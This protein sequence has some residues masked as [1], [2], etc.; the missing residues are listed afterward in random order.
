MDGMGESRA[1]STAKDTEPYEY[2]CLRPIE[3]FPAEVGGRQVVCLRDP[4]QYS[5]AVIYVP[6]E[7]A[8]IL[9][10][11]DGGHSLLDIQAAFARRFGSLLFREQLLEVIRSLDESLL[12]DSP[13]FAEHR[14]QVEA[15]FQAAATRPAALAGK[16]Y[17]TESV[18]L[19][20]TLDRFFQHTDGPGDCPPRAEAARLGA[21]V[22]P[23]IDYGRGGPCYAWGYREAAGLPE[24]DR[25]LILGTVH[26][27]IRRPFALSRK[28]FET[29]LGTVAI[30][31]EFLDRLVAGGA[32]VYLEDEFA[33]RGE[34]SIE[35]QAVFLR[36]VTP[37]EHSVR[38]V[39]I[40]CGSM[41]RQIT[42]RRSPAAEPEIEQFLTLLRDT[43]R[44]AGGR[45]VVLASADLAH[46]GPRFGDP[47]R[48]T[49][50]QLREAADA[51]RQLLTAVEAGDAEEVFRL[52]ARDGDRRRICGLAPI[53]SALRLVPASSGRL[54][55]YAQW[56]DPQGTVTF[57]AVALYR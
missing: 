39:P 11:F 1:G 42:D 19:R 24:V 40:L 8:S 43:T 27:P 53:Y 41:H 3:A 31:H 28:D 52:V 12:L 17:P 13:R 57:A 56:A 48:I 32:G 6:G 18:A 9:G 29:P 36:H 35:L 5:E 49:A 46:I 54:L 38:I 14:R 37:A 2:P 4:Q 7:T 51:D 45:T 25:W 33:H 15:A 23:H 47:H 30:D 21:L 34:H 26:A 10:L 20:E 55:R 22:L 16:S 50:G 44:S